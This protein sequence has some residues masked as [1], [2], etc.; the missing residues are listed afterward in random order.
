M[1]IRLWLLQILGATFVTPTTGKAS[2]L[3]RRRLSSPSRAVAVALLLS[4]SQW[5]GALLVNLVLYP[6]QRNSSSCV[7]SALEKLTVAT[8]LL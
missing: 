2:A 7:L 5:D 6:I 1:K 3:T 8:V 4:A